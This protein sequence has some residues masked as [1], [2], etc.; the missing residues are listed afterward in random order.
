M[1]WKY[2]FPDLWTNPGARVALEDVYLIPP[3]GKG[4]LQ[5]YLFTLEGLRSFTGGTKDEKLELLADAEYVINDSLD[6]LVRRDDFDKQEL[7]DWTRLFIRV[8]FGDQDPELVEASELER[9]GQ[10]SGEHDLAGVPLRGGALKLLF[11]HASGAAPRSL[12]EEALDHDPRVE[13]RT[14]VVHDPPFDPE[15][16]SMIDRADV[17]IAM[18]KRMRHVVK[19]VLKQTGLDK[20]V[21]CLHL[22]EHH[23]LQDPVYRELFR[24]RIEV[25]LQ[26]LAPRQAL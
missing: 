26:R 20:R 13:V 12:P 18:D 19:R 10:I 8:Q 24:E 23:D 3:A 7:L 17:V 4:G 2:F 16:R 14:F 1:Q 25:Y 11:L 6:M 9:S 5:S 21:V 22:P 15:E